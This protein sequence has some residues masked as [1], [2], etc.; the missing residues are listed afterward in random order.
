MVNLGVGDGTLHLSQLHLTETAFFLFLGSLNHIQIGS[1][2]L[3]FSLF[4]RNVH[5]I[6]QRR[7][8]PDFSDSPNILNQPCT[9]FVSKN[10]Q[11]QPPATSLPTSKPLRKGSSALCALRSST[12]LISTSSKDWATSSA[13][14]IRS[15][16]R[17]RLVGGGWLLGRDSFEVGHCWDGLRLA[18]MRC[19]LLIR[20]FEIHVLQVLDDARWIRF[21]T[22]NGQKN[23]KRY[24]KFICLCS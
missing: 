7:F 8:S 21:V 18:W 6:S 4:P 16:L 20:I 3:N 5:R 15:F 10:P 13:A 22:L 17:R 23:V 11:L 1:T 12:S 9:I 24:S 2:V 19:L 14:K